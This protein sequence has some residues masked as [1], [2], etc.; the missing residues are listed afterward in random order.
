MPRI[1]GNRTS[2]FGIAWLG[3]ML[4]GAGYY[5]VHA[6]PPQDAGDRGACRAD[7]GEPDADRGRAARPAR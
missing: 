3:L 5:N 2:R 4:V 7:G 6:A 1:T